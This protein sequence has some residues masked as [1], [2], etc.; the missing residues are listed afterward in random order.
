MW[1][2]EPSGLGVEVTA[3]GLLVWAREGVTSNPRRH[4][5]PK[6]RSRNR[7]LHMT[8]LMIPENPAVDCI[9]YNFLPGTPVNGWAC[10]PGALQREFDI[11]SSHS[12]VVPDLEVMMTYMRKLGR[13][14]IVDIDR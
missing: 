10:F 7:F 1:M 2:T 6:R 9:R 14:G 11:G 4:P 8:G 3:E 13:S 5:A 12:R